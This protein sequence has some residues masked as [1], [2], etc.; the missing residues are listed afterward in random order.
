MEKRCTGPCGEKKPLDAFSKRSK[1]KD[2]RQAWCKACVK[3]RQQEISKPK[4]PKRQRMVKLKLLYGLSV[5]EW[6]RMLIVQSGRCALC[7]DPMQNPH[8]DHSHATG[9][10]RGLLCLG[11]NSMLG[12]AERIGLSALEDYLRLGE[13]SDLKPLESNSVYRRFLASSYN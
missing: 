13:I 5:D 11:C 9:K 2:G 3:A 1:A 12:R 6:D 7:T 10:V 4:D 8:V